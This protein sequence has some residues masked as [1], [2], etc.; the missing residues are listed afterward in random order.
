MFKKLFHKEDGFTLVELLVTIAILAVLFGIT[1]LT[2][3]GIG[4]NASSTVNAAEKAVVNSAMDIYL[5]VA[6]GNSFIAN[7]TSAVITAGGTSFGQYL[8]TD[9]KCSYTW[10]A[11]GPVLVQVC[12]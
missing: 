11:N 5:A 2:L 8:R 6:A 3:S 10:A 9:T 7:G 1:T 12:P 4:T